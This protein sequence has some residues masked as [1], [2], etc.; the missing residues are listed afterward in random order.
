MTPVLNTTVVGD[1]VSS[2]E[3]P[4]NTFFLGYRGSIAH[5]MFVPSTNPDSIDDIDL[6][7]FV[8]GEPRHYFGL[9]EWGQR[10]TREI[11]SGQYDV[12]L[13]EARKAVSLLLQ[14]N[15][16]I[17]SMLWIEPKHRLIVSPAANALIDNRHLFVGKHVYNA[18]AGYAYQQLTKMETRDPAELRQYLALTAEAKFRGIHPNHKGEHFSYPDNYDLATGEARNAQ[19]HA[20]DVL[21]AHLHRYMKKG[22]NIG[23]MGDKRKQLVLRHGYDSKNA[24]HLVRLLRM[25][26]EFMST[27]EM[28]VE[29]PDAAELLDIKAGKWNLEDVKALADSLF[30]ECKVAR[31]KSPLPP[32]PDHDGA[33]KLLVDIVR[34]SLGV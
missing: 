14:G 26:I 28:I 22:E 3:Y 7:G 32:E 16:N 15:P 9:H 6:M 10:G 11:K 2:V 21:I 4:P 19:Q 31:D 8:F 27:G 20:D 24:A 18:F 33:E 17:M 13:Y 5:G 30:A 25:C 1:L 23:Y 29:R 12:V 34:Q